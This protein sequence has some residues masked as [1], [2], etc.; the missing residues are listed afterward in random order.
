[1]NLAAI[2]AAARQEACAMDGCPKTLVIESESDADLRGDERDIQSVLTNLVSNAVRYTPAEG[3]I[4][5]RWETDDRGR[6]S[7]GY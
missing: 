2:M 4:T 3:T 1:M 6:A 7:V 5:I